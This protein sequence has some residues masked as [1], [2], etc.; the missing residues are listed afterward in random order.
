[1]WCSSNGLA[2]IGDQKFVHTNLLW[3]KESA[4]S[5]RTEVKIKVD[6]ARRTDDLGSNCVHVHFFVKDVNI[7][8]ALEGNELFVI[9]DATTLS[10]TNTSGAGFSAINDSRLILLL[11]QHKVV[12]SST[13]SVKWPE[14]YS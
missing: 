11:Q 3:L 8:V 13:L 12:A 5:T 6:W 10:R 4:A 9:S 14:K 7:E 1:M 2:L